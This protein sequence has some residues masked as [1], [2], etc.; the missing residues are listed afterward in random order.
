MIIRELGSWKDRECNSCGSNIEVKEL[1][2]GN[3]GANNVIALCRGCRN[4]LGYIL[5]EESNK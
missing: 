1:V 5:T 3:K 4:D 2:I